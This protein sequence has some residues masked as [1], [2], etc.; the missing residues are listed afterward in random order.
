VSRAAAS[1][2]SSVAAAW[3]S[4][5]L[6]RTVSVMNSGNCETVTI[7][8]RSSL[9]SMS[10]MATPPIDTRPASGARSPAIS[11]RMEDLPAPERPTTAVVTPARNRC[12][13]CS[14]TGGRA[15]P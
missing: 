3:A 8:S 1:I 4:R 11:R 6:A 2:T 15:G 12:V 5:K 14:R 10:P 13:T 7:A 9:G